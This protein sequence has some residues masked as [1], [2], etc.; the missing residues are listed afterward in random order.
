[1]TSATNRLLLATLLAASS[2]LL[3]NVP[4]ADASPLSVSSS[5]ASSSSSSRIQE[6]R[7][8]PIR[9]KKSANLQGDEL[10]AWASRHRTKLQTKYD[11][12]D[13]SSDATTSATAARKRTEGSAS[14]VNF[15]SDSTWYTA[16]DVGTPAQS[17]N[18]VLDTGSADIWIASTNY[19]PSQSSTFVNQTTAFSIE[20]GSGD[21]SGYVGTDTFSVA[22]HTVEG[23]TFAVGTSVSSDL[24]DG[25]TEGIMGL[26]FQ[27]LSV[28]NAEPI[29]QSS[30]ESE[31]SFYLERAQTTST[32]NDGSGSGS[33]SGNGGP[34]IPGKR[35]YSSESEG[36]Y[37]TLGGRNSSLY[38]GDIN[39]SDVVSKG[40]WLITLGGVSTQGKVLDLDDLN[41]AVI[42]TGTTLTAGPADIIEQ[43]YAD[44]EG[45]SEI[46]G[47]AGYYQFPCST[48]VNAT[49]TFGNQEYVLNST[50][51]AVSEVTQDGSYC[52]GSFFSLGQVSTQS[53]LQWII[54]DSFLT[55]VY[56]IFSNGDTARVGF[57]ALADGLEN[58]AT[59]SST[60]SSTQ[61][62]SSAG[63]SS[64]LHVGLIV[65]ASM[66]A[67]LVLF[68]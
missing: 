28:N 5:S 24:E 36:G 15:E 52:M 45:A 55:S 6:P 8:F 10:I 61:A 41:K 34:G 26:A 48:N 40:Y 25:T 7:G 60:V 16:V 64:S 56:S 4:A 65:V 11:L 17:Y 68:S 12:R 30:G 53:T 43:F 33:G 22:G 58:G 18:L 1:M 50:A 35:A 13:A 51:F 31:F 38:Q 2:L 49:L 67:T 44:I 21:V 46:S 39:W 3:S 23:Q 29:W 32:S 9:R 14:L 57:A 37:F 66:L 63:P 62:A 47:A 19:T 54:G 59:T 27:T 42:D 20:Y